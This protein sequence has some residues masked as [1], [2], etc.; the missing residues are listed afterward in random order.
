MPITLVALTCRASDPNGKPVVGAIYR[1]ELNRSDAQGD[2]I[3]AP[4]VLTA[5]SDINGVAVFQIWPNALGITGSSYKIEATNPETRR[6]FISGFI[7]VPNAA[8][9]LEDILVLPS[10]PTVAVAP[11]TIDQAALKNRANHTGTQLAA[12]IS[13]LTTS[14]QAVPGFG[15]GAN[16]GISLITGQFPVSIGGLISAPTIRVES[17]GTLSDGLM[18]AADKLKLN[19][20]TAGATPNSTDAV[21]LNRANHT[22][23]MPSTAVSDFAAKVSEIVGAGQS[24]GAESVFS[25]PY[26]ASLTLDLSGAYRNFKVTAMGAMKIE[27][28]TGSAEGKSFQIAIKRGAAGAVT[29]GTRW[30]TERL[31]PSPFSSLIGSID[32]LRGYDAG[33]DGIRTVSLSVGPVQNT[34]APGPPAITAPDQAFNYMGVA[35]KGAWFETGAAYVFLD[36][37]AANTAGALMNRWVD[38]S[39][40]LSSLANAVATKTGTV[41]LTNTEINIQMA[42]RFTATTGGSGQTG[43]V[44]ADGFFMVQR[45]IPYGYPTTSYSDEAAVNTG[46]FLRY[47]GAGVGN[48][49][50]GD[51]EFSV[52]VGTGRVSV[53]SVPGQ[54]VTD[55][56]YGDPTTPVIVACRHDVAGGMIYMT[57]NGVTTSA[58][59]AGTFAPGAAA[60]TISGKHLNDIERSVKLYRHLHINHQLDVS[61]RDNLLTYFGQD[62]VAPP[63]TPPSPTPGGGFSIG[64]ATRPTGT[65]Y[66]AGSIKPANFTQLQMDTICTD[67][68]TYWKANGIQT[69]LGS[70]Y[71]AFGT[72]VRINQTVSEGIGYGM[73]LAVIFAGFDA[74]AKALFDDL[75]NVAVT[76]PA[77]SLG[78]ANLMEWKLDR[79]T[80]VVDSNG[81]T[82]LGSIPGPDGGGGWN[83]VDGDL[84]IAMAL[85]M[86]DRQFGSS[87]TINYKAKALL[88][89][90]AMKRR[91][92]RADGTSAGGGVS[93]LSRTSDYMIGHFR[94][95]RRATKDAFWD[96]AIE[97]SYALLARCQDVLAP[98]TKLIPDFLINTD[99]ASPIADNLGLGDGPGNP[100]SGFYFWNA[101]RIPLRV[102]T[103][104]LT[105]GD[106]RSR[107]V[108]SNLTDFFINKH[109]A[110]PALI[111]GGYRLDGTE[112]SPGG[113]NPQNFYEP[114]LV[115]GAAEARFQTY[116]NSLWS[117]ANT[118]RSTGYYATELGLMS[119]VVASGNWWNPL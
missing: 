91:N 97:R 6:S 73:I 44:A 75:Y 108:G 4:E 26:A 89:I 64:W 79:T 31:N 17:A 40:N 93:H 94:A 41:L 22:G 74:T 114:L 15:T 33:V 80:S 110:N 5:K 7:V 106:I 3:I 10:A 67:Q 55:V 12:T 46:R 43:V 20:I 105:A 14:V 69:G 29:F 38:R 36:A 37:T 27:N 1:A 87:G 2:I 118:N 81:V 21:L 25:V 96:V 42:E 39:A 101:C 88:V 113:Y 60:Y 95:F 115:T 54:I 63:V 52:G 103:D 109:G 85:L 70:R 65:A 34:P 92:F 77:Y 117:R 86:A 48:D 58:A 68:Y 100:N 18:S 35:R 71:V 45:L 119:L 49:G 107:T 13:D 56:P 111:T 23:T 62:A 57:C 72:G 24:G 30:E 51:F 59:V 16:G 50:R 76:H 90:D 112:T 47:F 78:E 53:R 84:D 104:Y 66:T 99:T 82:R 8:T 28:P 61:L 32:L 102:G 116:V 19:G 11:P 98:T 9:E 83:A